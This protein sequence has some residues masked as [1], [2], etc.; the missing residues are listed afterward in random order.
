MQLPLLQTLLSITGFR[1]SR[2]LHST[3]IFFY[4]RHFGTHL[5][6]TVH[7]NVNLTDV[8]KFS[9]LR[10][11]LECNKAKTIDGFPLTN[12]N[13]ARAVDLSKERYGQQHKITHATLQAL[14]QL[15]APRDNLEGIRNF[16]DKMET[17]IRTLESI[18][19]HP[20]TFGGL[21]V[22]VVLD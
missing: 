7:L 18:G 17:H 10:F 15:P 8:Q 14:L 13:Y 19:Q 20:D 6:S 1:N 11:L 5:K 4:G 3:V 21:L 22:P 12:A 16:D 2:F 9:Y